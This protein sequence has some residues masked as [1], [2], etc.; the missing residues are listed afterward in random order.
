MKLSTAIRIGSMTTKQIRF[1][2]NDEN[3]GRCALGAAVDAYGVSPQARVI[4]QACDLF[5]IL[6]RLV[7]TPK[8]LLDM[9]AYSISPLYSC[10][11]NLNDLCD[12]TREQIADYVESIENELETKTHNEVIKET[13]NQ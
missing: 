3:G 12:W 4:D 11:V 9:G 2:G 8:C 1:K 10:V 7:L 5:P 13:V 6:G